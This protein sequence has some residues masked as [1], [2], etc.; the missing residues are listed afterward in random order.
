MATEI[1]RLFEPFTHQQHQPPHRYQL[2]MKTSSP[3]YG[4]K[5]I[6]LANGESKWVAYYSEFHYNGREDICCGIFDDKWEAEQYFYNITNA[7]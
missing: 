6:V 3:G 4:I 1:R 2:I 5:N 7:R